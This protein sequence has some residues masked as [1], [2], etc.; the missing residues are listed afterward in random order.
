M[1]IYFWNDILDSDKNIDRKKLGNIVFNNKNKLN[2]LNEISILLNGME[3]VSRI[4]IKANWKQVMD[5]IV[6]L[7]EYIQTT[8]A[9]TIY[10]NLINKKS[11]KKL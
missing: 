4:K 11:R 1:I 6:S 2:K 8:N 7:G 9:D 5:Y 3:E 10:N